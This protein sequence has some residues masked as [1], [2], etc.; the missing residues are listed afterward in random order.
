MQFYV[1]TLL[2]YAGVYMIAC[3]GLNLQFGLVGILSFAYILFQ[4]IGAYVAAILSL[5]PPSQNAD[6]EQYVV[7]ASLPFPLPILAAALS[8]ALLA[9]LLGPV[10]LRRLR[11]DLQAIMMLVMSL[12]ATDV[13]SSDQSLLNGA[14]GLSLVPT[15]LSNTLTLSALQYQ[16]FY[17]GLTAVVCLITFLVVHQ[18]TVSPLGR[19]LRS[20]RE[21][22]SSAA[23][24]GKNVFALRMRAFVVGGAIAGVSGAL[25]VLFITAWSPGSW[26]YVETFVLF[27]AV[28]I[29][30][31][32]NN[33][34]VALGAVIVPVGSLEAVQYL[35]S[36][37]PPGMTDALQ[38]VAV[39]VLLLL[40]LWFRP[41]G[42]VPERRRRLLG[43][44]AREDVPASQTASVPQTQVSEQ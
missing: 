41:R 24:I 17:V 15:P 28:I 1:S 40:F 42:L 29:G 10:V 6:V 20:V 36:F 5:G 13:V 4:S 18:I 39:G 8:G 34:G 31:S 9:A 30:G 16:W 11:P 38:W 7:G 44:P 43:A 21:S 35:P 26:L 12:I 19:A 14:T 22:E 27:A 32:G 2:V 3:W 37:G 23:A 33:L 25:L